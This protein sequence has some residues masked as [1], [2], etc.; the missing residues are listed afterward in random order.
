MEGMQIL[1]VVIFLVGLVVVDFAAL[2]K[3]FDS[4]FSPNM[5]YERPRSW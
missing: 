2:R 5:K 1:G 3:G 4:R